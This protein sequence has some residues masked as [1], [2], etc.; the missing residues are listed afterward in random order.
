LGE[1]L[2]PGFKVAYGNEVGLSAAIGDLVRNLSRWPRE[3]L[4]QRAKSWSDPD[5]AAERLLGLMRSDLSTGPT[6]S[7]SG[8]LP[9][10]TEG[11]EEILPGQDRIEQRRQSSD[12]EVDREPH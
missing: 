4:A 12:R 11:A 10:N 9:K 5:L 7:R 1:L 6:G 8:P 3:E 2:P